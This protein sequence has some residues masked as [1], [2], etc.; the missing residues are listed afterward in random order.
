M[1]TYKYFTSLLKSFLSELGLNLHDFRTHYF[2]R[3]E[4][5]FTLETRAPLDTIF[6]MADWETDFVFLYLYMSL[7]FYL[8]AQRLIASEMYTFLYMIFFIYMN[9]FTLII[10]LWHTY[11]LTLCGFGVHIGRSIYIY[12]ISFSLS[13]ISLLSFVH[14]FNRLWTSFYLLY[15]TSSLVVIW[16]IYYSVLYVDF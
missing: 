7:T 11:Y 4:A 15:R 3:E 5:S 12:I 6:T 13:F 16:K 1:F 14:S 2:C 10:P 9:Y 8:S